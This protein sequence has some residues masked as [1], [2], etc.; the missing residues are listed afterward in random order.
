LDHIKV[1]V[2]M[3]NGICFLG[4]M[5]IWIKRYDVISDKMSKV[6]LAGTRYNSSVQFIVCFAPC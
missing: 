3:V 4:V 1:H 5:P 2:L 6:V